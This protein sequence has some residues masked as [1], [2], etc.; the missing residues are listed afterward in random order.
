MPE[1]YHVVY[2]KLR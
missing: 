1:S 2:S